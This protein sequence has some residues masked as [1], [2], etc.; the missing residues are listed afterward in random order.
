MEIVF[1]ASIWFLKSKNRFKTK[2]YWFSFK[3]T[4]DEFIS[5]DYPRVGIGYFFSCFNRLKK[6]K[7]NRI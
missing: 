3:K 7:K 6:D 2:P 4:V 5:L 1:N